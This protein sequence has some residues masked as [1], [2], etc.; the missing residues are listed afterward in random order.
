MTLQ[1]MDRSD[2]LRYIFTDSLLKT[3]QKSTLLDYNCN[4]SIITQK[5]GNFPSFV[6]VNFQGDV[7]DK[8]A[9]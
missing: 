7:Q 5:L 8:T 6:N 3:V 2:M 9:C 1:M 4:I